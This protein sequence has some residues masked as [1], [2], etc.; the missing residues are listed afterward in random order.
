MSDGSTMIS[1]GKLFVNGICLPKSTYLVGLVLICHIQTKFERSGYY[2]KH[3][4]GVA[5]TRHISQY[6]EQSSQP[7]QS[8]KLY[9]LCEDI[10]KANDKTMYQA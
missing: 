10:K 1:D 9:W 8:R 4:L 7:V 2:H 3:R 6:L 5:A